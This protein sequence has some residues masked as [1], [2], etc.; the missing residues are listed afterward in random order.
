VISAGF[1]SLKYIY[2]FALLIFSVVVVMASVFQEQTNATADMGLPS[3]A[4][5][6]IFWFLIFWLA[7]MEGGQVRAGRGAVGL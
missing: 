7:M 1:E 6:F 4:A 3:I 2:S 5:F